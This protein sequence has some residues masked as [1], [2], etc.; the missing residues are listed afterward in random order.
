MTGFARVEGAD[1][2]LS[3]AWELRSVNG[4]GLDVRLRIPAGFEVLEVPARKRVQEKF[5]RGNLQV[6]LQ[7]SWKSR[8][9]SLKIDE[10]L[11]EQLI[12]AAQNLREKVG[13]E[14]PSTADL[15]SIRGVVDTEGSEHSAISEASAKSVLD[16]LAE[17]LEELEKA[18]RE[19]GK[20]IGR[21]LLGQVEKITSMIED[22]EADPSRKPETILKHLNKQISK[23]VSENSE[24][25]EQRLHQEALLLATKADITEE[26]DR[27]KVHVTSANTLISNGGTIGRKLDF[28]AQEFNR[29]CNTICSK[30]N[31]SVVTGIGLDMK[32]VIDQFRE[33]LQN[34]E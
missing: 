6:S 24:M 25:D 28:L 4:K 12:A 30:S 20:G 22:I 5:S 2:A 33:Q 21:V 34:M 3:W 7:I 10:E 9:K 31:S 17:G 19:E 27:L 29:E 14:M 1:D 15:L 18:R 8:E 11:V 26:L 32:L 13:G 16:N 23:L